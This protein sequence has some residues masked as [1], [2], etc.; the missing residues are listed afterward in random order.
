MPKLIQPREFHPRKALIVSAVLLAAFAYAYLFR[1]REPAT[2]AW[3]GETMGTTYHITLAHSTLSEWRLRKLRNH[4]GDYLVEINRMMSTYQPDS[5]ISQ[6]NASRSTDGF[7]VSPGFL[8]VVRAAL[9]LCRESGGAFDPTVESLSAAWGFGP[10]KSEA[11]PSEDTLQAVRQRVGCELLTIED[12]DRLRK[13]VPEV[14]ITLDAIATGYAADGVAELIRQA[15][16]SNLLVEIGGEGVALGRNPEEQAW[17]I[18]IDTP[19]YGSAPGE[20][21]Q[22]VVHLAGQGFATS[23][24]YRNFR[25]DEDGRVRSHI[26]DPR[27]GRPVEHRLASVTILAPDCLAADGL[28]TTVFVLGPEAGMEFI[29]RRD[30]VEGLLIIRREDG[31]FEERRSSGFDAFTAP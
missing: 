21:L 11:P 19:G 28:S 1:P 15:G 8:S 18:G 12:P 7:P 14:E 10:H 29:E 6:F 26:I 24:D 13:G 27:T 25:E 2:A 23:G 31:S 9:R 30:G 17:R 3:S 4:V 22:T 5:E 16:V 20:S